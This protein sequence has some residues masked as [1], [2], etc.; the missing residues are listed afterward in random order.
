MKIDGKKTH[1]VNF[2]KHTT[3]FKVTKAFNKIIIHKKKWMLTVTFFCFQYSVA[4]SSV[5]GAGEGFQ[6]D[7]KHHPLMLT[8]KNMFSY[9]SYYL[10]IFYIGFGY[11]Q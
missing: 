6:I 2:S 1:N 11:L 4:Q 9:Y 7:L 5:V 3:L 8:K 10:G